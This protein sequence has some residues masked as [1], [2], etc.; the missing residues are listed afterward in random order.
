M[1]KDDLRARILAITD[2]AYA[3]GMKAGLREGITRLQ[4]LAAVVPSSVTKAYFI[5]LVRNTAKALE[6][7]MEGG[8]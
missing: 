4:S 3:L 1:T 7:R 2:E 5:E 8:E 6:K